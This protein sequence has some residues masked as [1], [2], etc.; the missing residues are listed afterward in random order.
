[1]LRTSF[2]SRRSGGA[3]WF[4]ARPESSLLARHKV[5]LVALLVAHGLLA[6]QLRAR[7]VFTFG[8]DAAY[9]LLSRSLKALTYHEPQFVGTPIAARFPPGYPAFLA[10][11]TAPAGE[12]LGII[13]VAGILV[14]T[15]GLAFMF[16]VIRRRWSTDLAFLATAAAAVN[17]VLV[18]NAGSV[19]SETLYTTLTLASLWAADRAERARAR[20]RGEG[21]PALAAGGLAI[22]AALT[23]SAGVTLLAALGLHWLSRRRYRWVLIFGISSAVTVGSWLAWTVVA[24]GREVRRSYVDD[25]VNVRMGDGSL[26]STVVQRIRR[27]VS[28]YVGQS[29][30]AELS[31]PVTSRT[32]LDNIAWVVVLGSL[33][34]IGLVS[35]WGRW[36]AVV[37]YFG[38]YSGLLAVWAYTIDRFL[39]PVLPLVIA[40]LVIGAGVAASALARQARRLA[41]AVVTIG[42]V[43]FALGDDRRLV[44]RAGDCDR[45]RVDCAAPHSLDFLD[46]VAYLATH[47]PRDARVVTPKAPTL[48][49][50]SG[51]QALYWD[52][53]VTQTPDSF[54]SL[55]GRERVS[56]ILTT[57]VF[58]DHLTLLR[59]A[60]ENCERLDLVRAF[61]PQTL[62]LAARP[63]GAPPARDGRACMMLER[64]EKLAAYITDRG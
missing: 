29:I 64:A 6:W 23:R 43:V 63:E 19:T 14:S 10:A 1:L 33:L 46:A 4:E 3:A 42:L 25:A 60:H 7:G 27:N 47:S 49:Y 59:L 30:L 51:R 40:L 37:W 18:T 39:D 62:L 32:R 61:S 5:L 50:H 41:P 31:L 26:E 20:P 11:L 38:A 13:S 58:S 57:P 52:E 28:T 12:R 24:P 16:D 2:E 44:E 15:V 22:A 45:A 36:N 56:Y 48:Y 17:P 34:A 53:I 35:A 55:L 54:G 8:D 21:R 9:L